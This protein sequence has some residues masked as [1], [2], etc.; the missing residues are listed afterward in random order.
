MEKTASI[1]DPM[2]DARPCFIVLNAGSGQHDVRLTAG[3]IRE[4]LGAAGR[5]HQLLLAERGRDLPHLARQAVELAKA[6]DGIVVAAGGDGT[7]NAVAQAAL[8]CGQPF[9]V[10]PQGTFNYFGRVHGISQ[11]T[12]IATEALLAATERPV[13]VGLINDRVFLVNAS[14]GLY[15]QLLEDR[16]A[17]KKRFGRSRLVAI[18]SGLLS[19]LR[20]RRQLVLDIEIEGEARRIRTPTLFVGNN[21]LQLTQIGIAEAEALGR[22]RLVAIAMKPVGTASMIGLLLRGAFGRLGEADQVISFPL[23]SLTV[24]PPKRR[25]VRRYKVAMDGEVSR[26]AAPLVF[27]VSP[28]PLL[29]MVPPTPVVDGDPA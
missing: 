7:I 8:G 25:R 16:E 6:E 26:L 20:E 19:F 1:P 2:S 5:R 28:E 13:Q 3:I 29:L 11:D 12:R 23:R 9:A 17:F 14:L 22:G 10:L 4:V 27:Q 15:P 21:A 24:R 18:A